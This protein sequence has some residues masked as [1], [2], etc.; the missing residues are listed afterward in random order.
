MMMSCQGWVKSNQR[1]YLKSRRKKGEE[2][3][4]EGTNCQRALNY[5]WYIVQWIHQHWSK[6]LELIWSSYMLISE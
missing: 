1:K 5:K 4:K 3:E 6:I 2:S